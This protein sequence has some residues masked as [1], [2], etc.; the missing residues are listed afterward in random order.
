MKEKKPKIPRAKVASTTAARRLK[1][2]LEALAA[3]PGTPE[4]GEAAKGKLE[5]LLAKYDFTQNKED[6][7][8][9]FVGNFQK[10]NDARPVILCGDPSLANQI[11]WALEQSTGIP[12]LFRGQELFAQATPATAEQFKRIA[13]TLQEGFERLWQSF[14]T[15][16]TVTP[17]D[18]SLFWRGLGDGLSNTP[19]LQGEQLPKRAVIQGRGRK[20]KAAV[21]HAAGLGIH[22]YSIALDL[23]Q[24][25]R[26]NVPV[27]EVTNQLE[28]KRP[29]QIT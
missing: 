4:E 29:K 16:P 26:F 22:P 3:A 21:G 11:K 28:E 7:E 17:L 20:T 15:F 9:I 24:Q 1:V 14:S 12:C 5:R 8:G 18:K 13:Q 23:G 25:L 6:R 10:S 2:R 19:R 27:Q